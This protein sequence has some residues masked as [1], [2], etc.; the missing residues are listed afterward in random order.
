MKRSSTTRFI[1]LALVSLMV[2]LTACSGGAD[3]PATTKAPEDGGNSS[4]EVTTE[5]ETT[6]SVATLLGFEKEDNKGKTF[7]I[8]D[9]SLAEYQYN[10]ETLTGEVVNDAVYEKNRAVEDYLGIKLAVTIETGGWN[11]RNAFNA[12]IT[13][14]VAAGDDTIDFVSSAMTITLPL[15]R[16]GVFIEGK[17]LK[18][19]DLSHPWW[20]ANQ[21][22]QFAIAGKVYGFLGDASLSVYK[23]LNVIFFN[24]K[25]W[26]DNKAGDPYEWVR[27]GKWVYDKYLEVAV[28]M[29]RDLN[30]DGK[31]DYDNDQISLLC[32]QV[33]NGTMMEA[34]DIHIVQVEK[35]GSISYLGLTDKFAECYEKQGKLMNSVGVGCVSSIDDRSFKSQ[36][37]FANGKVA[38]MVNFLYSTEHLREME[39]DYGIIPLP[40]YDENQDH[41]ITRI[42]T[43]TTMIYVPKTQKDRDLCSKAMEAFSYFTREIVVPKYYE[44]ALKEK[45]ARDEDVAEMLDIIRAGAMTDFESVWSAAVSN[46]MNNEFRFNGVSPNGSEFTN[47][48]A[49]KFASNGPGYEASIRK[50]EEALKALADD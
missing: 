38:T 37:Y 26:E 47:T 5:A 30:G 28:S 46:T 19:M 9:T 17:Q 12:K 24:K 8:M 13:Q 35:D 11:E 42:G 3:K 21:Y 23:D 40:K 50:L 29:T 10:A 2:V 25:I 48:L 45:Y 31:I 15:A 44:S 14:A 6:V 4:P 39:D 1:I 41:Y 33:P 7:T 18:Y 22:E 20:I 16:D 43:S 34:L 36:K 27:A 32:E 49:S